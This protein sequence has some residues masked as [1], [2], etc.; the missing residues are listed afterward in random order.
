MSETLLPLKFTGHSVLV[1]DQ[2]LLPDTEEYHEHFDLEGVYESIRSMELR[3]APLIGIAAAYGMYLGVLREESENQ[4]ILYQRVMR[5]A[6]RLNRSR[7][8]AKNLFWATNRITALVKNNLHKT[9]LEIKNLILSEAIRINEEDVDICKRIGENFLTVL[10]KGMRLLTHCNAG[11]LATYRY[12]TATAPMYLGQERG[13]GFKVFVDETRPYNQGARLT[14]YELHRAGIDAT[15][16]CDNMAAMVLSKGWV[17]AILVGS[18]RVTANGDTANK[19][20]TL[21]LSILAR[22]FGIPFYVATP[23]PTLDFTLTSGEEIPIEERDAQEITHFRGTR[24]TPEGIRVF[25]P[26]FDVSPHENIT[27]I[28]TER[29]IAWPPFAQSLRNVIGNAKSENPGDV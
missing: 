24:V 26:A 1:L 28:V 13:W 17:D 25:N 10:K 15:L 21:N 2:R 22:Y 11:A 20:G 14:A 3:G 16:I 6:E 9:T 5:N 8:T 19:V 18:D 7:P 12:G 23:T 27:A 29:G 4:E